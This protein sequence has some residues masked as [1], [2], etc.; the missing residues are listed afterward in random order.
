MLSEKEGKKRIQ[1]KTVLLINSLLIHLCLFRG[2]VSWYTT[3]GQKQIDELN[4]SRAE[5]S[6]K[7][8]HCKVWPF[9]PCPTALILCF[10]PSPLWIN[11][12]LDLGFQGDYTSTVGHRLA[13]VCS[14]TK[15]CP[16]LCDPTDCSLLGSSVHGIVQ[17]RILEWGAISSS[18]GS[19]CLGD[20]THISC[21]SCISRCILYHWATWE[22]H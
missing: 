21:V 17:A 22:A 4:S 14:T 10:C 6:T 2:P 18:R 20:Q 13:R 12:K 5:V 11:K 15:S 3:R 16:N 19:S 8:P 9:L 1:R 7:Y